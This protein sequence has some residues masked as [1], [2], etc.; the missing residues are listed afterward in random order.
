MKQETWIAQSTWEG[1]KS[2]KLSSLQN[3]GN[4]QTGELDVQE[5]HFVLSLKKGEV[6]L[7]T[8]T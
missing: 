7:I 5:N 8:P 3:S 2:K 4:Q 6:V 1:I